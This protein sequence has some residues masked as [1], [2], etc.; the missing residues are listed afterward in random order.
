[1]FISFA[2][3]NIKMSVFWLCGSHPKHPFSYI[4]VLLMYNNIIL[5]SVLWTLT[6]E[7]MCMPNTSDHSTFIYRMN[8]QGLAVLFHY[9]TIVF[10][11][12]DFY[13]IPESFDGSKD[14]WIEQHGFIFRHY[15]YHIAWSIWHT[16]ILIIKY[17]SS[18]SLLLPHTLIKCSSLY[19]RFGHEK[20]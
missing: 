16:L 18:P 2:H 5:S 14:C 1:M 9:E 12:I 6:L 7:A 20:H 3:P 19:T 15:I 4:I 8:D 13:R 11:A 17:L 10:S